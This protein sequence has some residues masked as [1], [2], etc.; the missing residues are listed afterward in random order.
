MAVHGVHR[1]GVAFLGAV[2]AC[3]LVGAV[4]ASRRP[5]NSIVWI[6]CAATLYFLEL[7]FHAL[8]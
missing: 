7:S 5:R 2:V 6:F 4:V 3:S 8:G 1:Q